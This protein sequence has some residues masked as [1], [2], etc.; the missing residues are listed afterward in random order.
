MKVNKTIALICFLAGL[1]ALGLWWSITPHNYEDCVLRYANP[2]LTQA[3][4]EKLCAAKFGPPAGR[5]NNSAASASD[6]LGMPRP[7][8][9]TLLWVVFIL[10]V[11]AGLG[12][13]QWRRRY[14]LSKRKP[15]SKS[16]PAGPFQSPLI[17]TPLTAAPSTPASNASEPAD[18]RPSFA[19]AADF[20]RPAKVAALNPRPKRPLIP[21]VN[22]GERLAPL[23]GIALVLFAI[24]FFT[25]SAWNG[26]VNASI[27]LGAETMF[28]C[29]AGCLL[30]LALIYG[31]ICA[32]A[33]QRPK[34]PRE[35]AIFVM[36]WA[37]AVIVATTVHDL[38][39]IDKSSQISW[40]V[41]A[42]T[43]ACL[44]VPPQRRAFF[45][46]VAAVDIAIWLL[47]L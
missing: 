3:Y 23:R 26:G 15:E 45:Y 5:E 17:S 1:I 25:S 6:H 35:M 36:G 16:E 2:G 12:A 29:L 9:S 21:P 32:I 44:L 46:V 24:A 10:A 41:G 37:T 18:A 8:E 11:L 38:Y 39:G 19:E 34:N 28:E 14:K 31:G 30:G 42:A 43:G 7:N 47:R 33:R 22:E 27:E 20:V 40:L 4:L 13:M